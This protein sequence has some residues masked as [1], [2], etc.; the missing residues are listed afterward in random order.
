[1]NTTEFERKRLVVISFMI[2]L[3]WTSGVLIV[4]EKM[5]SASAVVKAVN[6]DQETNVVKEKR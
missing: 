2:I 3:S 4:I 5:K 1:M 6:L